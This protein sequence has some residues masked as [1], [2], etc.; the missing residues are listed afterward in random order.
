MD[1]SKNPYSP[2]AG[3]RPPALVGRE[4]E[5][6]Q[7]EIALRRLGNG[8]S[9][10]S[11]MLSGLRG[12][13]KTVL[14]NEFCGIAHRQRWV[15]QQIE[16]TRDLNLPRIM[17]ERIRIALLQLSAGQR[18]AERARRGLS[19]LQSFKVRWNLPE[20]GEVE[21]G[22]QPIPGRADTG[23]LQEDLADLFLEMGEYARDRGV[24]VLFAIDEA[25]YLHKDQLG[26]LIMGL[27]K[28]SQR[29]LPF[30]VACAGLPSLPG[31]AGEA[32][33]YTERLFSF[34]TINSLPPVE[35]SRA[36]AEPAGDQQV[37]WEFDALERI[38]EDTGG[39]PYF[40]QEFGRQA[41]NLA[42][43]PNRITL[44]DAKNSVPVAVRALDRGFFNVRFD[45]TTNAERE[46]LAAMA[47]LG[48]GPHSSG[49]VAA[50][51]GKTTRQ[52]GPLR[53]SVI[54][55]GLCHAPRHGEIAFTVPMFDRFVQ[56]RMP[57]S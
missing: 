53:D 25:Q 37:H 2:S 12:V 54:K 19:V 21:L 43:G 27:H 29:Q 24:G 34:L 13:G 32:R 56:R 8:Y 52:A 50:A 33:S 39:Y 35:A 1:P 23:I 11:F 15:Y 10:R 41:W 44:E 46:Y 47:S 22:I 26:P 30:M 6:Q 28:V 31:L 3:A 14:L 16:A 18:L 38:V 45:R 40:L 36:L 49:Q 7:F 48:A 17:A 9:D 20:G 55:K 4:E 51:M 57:S 42:S 5:L